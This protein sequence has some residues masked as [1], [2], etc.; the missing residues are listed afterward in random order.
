[1][2]TISHRK[3]SKG[4]WTML[5]ID[6]NNRPIMQS[7]ARSPREAARWLLIR[8]NKLADEIEQQLVELGFLS[9]AD[10]EA[11]LAEE[12]AP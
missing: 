10:C 12:K 4:E 9:E 6:G 3:D 8:A 5:V 2:I 1:M 11:A 7:G